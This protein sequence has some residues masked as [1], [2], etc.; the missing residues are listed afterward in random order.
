MSR[1]RDDGNKGEFEKLMGTDVTRAQN[2]DLKRPPPAPRATRVAQREANPPPRFDVEE[3]G[4]HI[5]GV[6]RGIDRRILARI[7]RGE[8]PAEVRIDLHGLDVESAHPYVIREIDAAHQLGKRCV[9][10]IHGRGLH[11]GG[12]AVLKRAVV[13][14]VQEA[15]LARRV[16]V[17]V[18]APPSDGGTGALYVYL[19]KRRTARG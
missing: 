17:F 13:D 19:R 4:E 11:S 2:R 5:E 1:S 15:P 10:L 16:M 6:A 8:L 3:W 9:A 12:D 7:K 18:S 14:W